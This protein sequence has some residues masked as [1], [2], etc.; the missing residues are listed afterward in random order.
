[1]ESFSRPPCPPAASVLKTA[2]TTRKS[3][4]PTLV[5][6]DESG[7]RITV[8][9]GGAITVATVGRNPGS[10]ITTTNP[11]VSRDHSEIRLHG[12]YALISDKGSSNGTF[13]NDDEVKKPVVLQGGDLIKCG[14]FEI[15]YLEQAEDEAPPVAPPKPRERAPREAASRPRASSRDRGRRV[16][17]SAANPAID[18]KLDEAAAAPEPAAAAPAP[19]GDL[20]RKVEELQALVSYYEAEGDPAELQA[21]VAEAETELTRQQAI[22]QTLEEQQE[23]LQLDLRQQDKLIGELENRLERRDMEI[24]NHLEKQ[25]ELRGQLAHQAEQIDDLRGD[26]NARDHEIEDLAYKHDEAQRS[27]DEGRK[28]ADVQGH[29]IQDFKAQLSQKSRL[30]EELQKQLDIMTFDLKAANE[31]LESV[32]ESSTQGGAEVASLERKVRHLQEFVTDK[33]GI[34]DEL[35]SVTDDQ[36]E[37]IGL[38]REDGAGLDERNEHA[39]KARW[40]SCAR[41]SRSC[42]PRV[43]AGPPRTSSTSSSE[44]TG[45]CATAS[46]NW[47]RR[48]VPS[49]RDPGARGAATDASSRCSRPTCRNSTKRTSC[50]ESA[51][52]RCARGGARNPPMATRRPSSERTESSGAACATSRSRRRADRSTRPTS[53]RPPSSTT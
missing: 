29:E 13:V 37:E 52:R 19:D 9:F 48:P 44:P 7:D 22:A 39:G 2:A 8:E 27:V 50:S 12:P 53:K 26:I 6:T 30:V 15:K 28:S 17:S 24:E 47:R 21:K 36:A 35:K 43:E 51:S 1:M 45:R 46:K 33:E 3:P 38:M 49:R 40:R 31:E 23:Q 11:S 25:K 34:I 20:V 10:V 16:Q 18:A 32:S 5:Y 14:D 4:L 42:A 41:R